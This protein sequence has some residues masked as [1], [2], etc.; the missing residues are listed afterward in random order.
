MCG[1]RIRK[2]GL[3]EKNYLSLE[4]IK[5][6]FNDMPEYLKVYLW[7]GE[8]L[9]HPKFREIVV[10][11]LEKKSQITIN[12]NGLLLDKYL[13]F[14]A[15]A[16]LDTLI[17]SLDGL[18]EIHD[19]IRNYK[20]LFARIEKS[21][22]EYIAILHK[23][24]RN[25]NV[26]I[27]F[28]VQPENYLT[29]PVFC[30]EIKSWDIKAISIDF[31][32]LVDPDLARQFRKKT[33]R[34]Y[35]K[36]IVS[37]KSYTKT[38]DNMFNYEILSGTYH[39]LMNKYGY[40]IRQRKE[41]YIVNE[42]N[43]RI[44]H[45]KPGILLPRLYKAPWKNENTPCRKLKESISVDSNGNIVICPDLPDTII[46]DIENYKFSD[47]YDLSKFNLIGLDKGYSALCCR[48]SHRN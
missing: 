5:T 11:F 7:G 12:T 9:L 17:V 14:L 44:F 36:D 21:L 33:L 27:N 38:K 15:N 40:F 39:D 48:C 2:E 1:Q 46:A 3:K 20:G 18:G 28:V 6:F 26:V 35:K 23:N 8:P 43:L 42:E 37:W 4:K 32:Y 47:F 45:E 13:L 41:N 24:K 16:P 29:M 10:F 22:K 19:T 31:L 30:E 34:L 25:T